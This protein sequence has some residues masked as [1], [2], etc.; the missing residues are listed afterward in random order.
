MLIHFGI[1]CDDLHAR[2]SPACPWPCLS[3]V[4]RFLPLLALV[5]ISGVVVIW[6][7]LPLLALLVGL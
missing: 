2:E 7:C 4:G 1:F 5:V 6:R 3:R